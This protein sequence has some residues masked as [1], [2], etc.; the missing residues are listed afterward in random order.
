MFTT[1]SRRPASAQ[2]HALQA[3]E[4]LFRPRSGV[5]GTPIRPLPSADNDRSSGCPVCGARH[6]I[7]PVRSRHRSPRAVEHDWLCS[8]CDH[9]W[10]TTARIGA[11]TIM[12]GRGPRFAIGTS[13][14]LTAKYGSRP[15]PAELFVIVALRPS[16]SGGAHY[17]IKSPAESCERVVR[18]SEL[19]PAGGRNDL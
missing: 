11:P 13:V 18:E 9:A 14:R 12:P 10:T 7:A 2:R 16:D 5:A 19:A 8:A 17:R 4:A 1:T 6:P 3:A 15:M